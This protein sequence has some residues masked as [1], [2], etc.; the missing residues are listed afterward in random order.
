MTILETDVMKGILLVTT[1]ILRQNFFYE[2][3]ILSKFL[4]GFTAE[5]QQ[6]LSR[7]QASAEFGVLDELHNNRKARLYFTCY[8]ISAHLRD[9]FLHELH[10]SEQELIAF[11]N[12]LPKYTGDFDY[13]DK[14]G[15]SRAHD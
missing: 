13:D 10:F 4:C 14:Q 15:C 12:L 9:F 5:I 3:E 6:E 7:F 1:S 2:D 8:F 11:E